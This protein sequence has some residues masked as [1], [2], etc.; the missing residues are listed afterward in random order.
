MMRPWLTW[1][2]AGIMTTGSPAPASAYL[3]FGTRI[4]TSSV[5]V[6]W[7]RPIPYFVTERPGPGV[8]VPDLRDAIVRAF[9]TW[10]SVSTATVQG[11]FQGL[12]VAPPGG[13]DGRT[14]L[15][16]LDR[17]DLDRVLGATSLLL[18]AT[19][20]EILEADVFF[21]THFNWSTAAAGEPGRVDLESI[22]LHEIG[23]LLG[24]GHSALGETEMV[25]GG[26]RVIATGAVMFPIALSAGAIADRQLQPDDRAGISDVYPRAGFDA[27]ASS[28][29]GRVTKNGSGV[30]GAHVA[31]YNL[32]TG[33]LIGGFA[34]S[35]LGEFVIGGLEPGTYLVRAEPLDDADPD[36]FF[37]GPIDVDFRVTYGSRLVIAP[38][39]GGSDPVDLQVRPK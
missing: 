6:K 33:V 10:Q 8:G 21:N 3:K 35:A 31:A 13:P 7:N 12:T 36:S 23:H 29:S 14:T 30:F 27:T 18:D 11:Q 24:L 1:L 39:G 16:F 5:D 26:R 28:I 19:T 34:L 2:L 25:G 32:E 20:G 15:G 38:E 9:G 22:A 4:G 17:P 37:E